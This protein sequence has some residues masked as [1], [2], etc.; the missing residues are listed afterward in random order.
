MKPPPVKKPEAF[1]P[2]AAGGVP[3][4]IVEDPDLEDEGSLVKRNEKEADRGNRKVH[5]GSI[6]Q[7]EDDST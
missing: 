3:D 4:K 2:F 7:E 6:N 5:E 1:N